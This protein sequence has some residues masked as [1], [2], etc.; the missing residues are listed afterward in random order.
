MNHTKNSGYL[1]ENL[2][3]SLS[4]LQ[5]NLLSGNFYSEEMYGVK[6]RGNYIFVYGVGSHSNVCW[7]YDQQILTNQKIKTKQY[8]FYQKMV[9]RL[10]K[11]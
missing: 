2:L 1:K 7:L 6:N 4:D 8:Q 9:S 3:Y 10:R 5:N 11:D